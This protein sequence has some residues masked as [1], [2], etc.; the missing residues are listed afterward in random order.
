MILELAV[1]DPGTYLFVILECT[2]FHTDFCIW[3]NLASQFLTAISH[4]QSCLGSL[5][6]ITYK[7]SR[8]SY[9]AYAVG[10]YPPTA[11]LQTTHAYLHL[12]L[13]NCVLVD[14]QNS[15]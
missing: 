13:W 15:S 3:N 10:N 1:S 7:G 11:S 6:V 9:T 4:I 2:E 14:T 5:N 12:P 8:E